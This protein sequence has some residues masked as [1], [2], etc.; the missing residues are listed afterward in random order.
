MVL[1]SPVA[2]IHVKPPFRYRM[3]TH[4]PT[5]QYRLI[6]A[7]VQLQ[8]LPLPLNAMI[9]SHLA[10]LSYREVIV[11]VEAGW[12]RRP[13]FRWILWCFGK[14]GVVALYETA[15][16]GVGV[17]KIGHISQMHLLHQPVLQG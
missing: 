11:Q 15:Q 17:L 13:S 12:Q 2:M 8:H 7:D 10:A 9:S 3:H 16:E 14:A 1:K 6:S 4:A 5:N